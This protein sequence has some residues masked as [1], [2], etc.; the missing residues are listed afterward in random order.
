MVDK[1]SDQTNLLALNAAI[2]AARAGEAGAGFAVVAEEVQRLAERS[3]VSVSEISVIS[4]EISLSL[5]PVMNSI[6]AVQ[7]GTQQ[8]NALTQQVVDMTIEQEK[9][10]NT[11]VGAVNSMALVA[12]HTAVAT[13]E[14]AA[15]IDQQ[16]STMEDVAFST[17]KLS[18]IAL[19]LRTMISQHMAQQP[20]CPN[21]TPCPIFNQKCCEEGDSSIFREYCLGNFEVCARKRLKDSGAAVPLSLMPDGSTVN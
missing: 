11:M 1:T 15:S 20:L 16:R 3:A 14:I 7:T 19:D 8:T 6:E 12:E 5:L 4:N 2:E 13:E 17:K 10:S 9:A 21:L 18:Q